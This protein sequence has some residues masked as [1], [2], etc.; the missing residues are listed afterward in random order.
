MLSTL[1]VHVEQ[2]REDEKRHHDISPSVI[3]ADIQRLEEEG[4]YRILCQLQTDFQK[5]GMVWQPQIQHS[6][7]S[8]QCRTFSD[9][10]DVDNRNYMIFYTLERLFHNIGEQAHQLEKKSVKTLSDV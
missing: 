9:L 1:A 10:A 3:H 4:I 7:L 8:Q 6:V 5:K 2:A